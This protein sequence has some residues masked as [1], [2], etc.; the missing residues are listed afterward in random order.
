MRDYFLLSKNLRGNAEGY[1]EISENTFCKV[2][3]KIREPLPY[4][5]P[6][7]INLP[8]LLFEKESKLEEK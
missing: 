3:I 1:D 2:H 8:R 5:P 4:D 7:L 6:I